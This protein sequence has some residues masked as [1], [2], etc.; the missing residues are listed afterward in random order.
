M[1]LNVLLDAWCQLLGDDARTRPLHLLIAGAGEMSAALSKQITASGLTDS[2]TLLGRISDEDLANLYRASDVNVVPSLSFEGYGL[3][4]LEAAASGTPTIATRVG[5]L[6]EA[7]AGLDADL[8]VA[9]DKPGALALRLAAAERGELPDRVLT[10][11]WAS[12]HSWDLVAE[13]NRALYAGVMGEV[14]SKLRVAYIGHVAQLS[15]GEIAL[16]RLID[17][18]DEVEA[19]VILAEDGPLVGRLLATGVSVEV[20]PM[21]E[22]TRDLRKDRVGPGRVPL[23][24]VIDTTTYAFRLSRRLRAIKPD[25]VHTNTLKAGYTDLLLPALPEFP[26]CGTSV[27]ALPLTTYRVPPCG[28]RV[29]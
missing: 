4:V 20:L 29:P 7:L 14:P 9:P 2:V 28:L 17:A 10:R 24:A 27:I 22:R 19:H 1:G 5:G 15:G 25:L 21:R 12:G 8:I 16:A 11:Q 6:P 13:R 26:R 23:A 18:L 3:V